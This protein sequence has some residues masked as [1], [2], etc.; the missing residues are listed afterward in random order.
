M[1]R[2]YK[3]ASL[4]LAT[5]LTVGAC[6]DDSESENAE[7]TTEESTAN[8]TTEDTTTE[9]ATEESSSSNKATTESSSG[10]GTT[11]ESSGTTSETISP[12]EIKHNADEAVQ[13]ASDNF[14]GELKSLEFEKENDSWVYKVELENESEEYE[15]H[16]SAD[17]LSIINE[18][19]ENNDDFDTDEHFNYQDAV[20]AEDV[21]QTAMDEKDGKLEGWSL[22]KDDGQLEYEVELKQDSNS[23]DVKIN[24]ENG[25]VLKTDD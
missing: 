6:S 10:G 13:T 8:E 14:E 11:D 18:E 2:R 22:D 23:H 3:L 20:S 25:E 21:I 17:D 15:A 4:L 5:S 1:S 24:A 7:T 16:I 12:E 19:T 9:E